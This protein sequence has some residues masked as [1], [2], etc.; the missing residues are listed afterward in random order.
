MEGQASSVL[1]ASGGDRVR[2]EC[3]DSSG[4]REGL[5]NEIRKFDLQSVPKA[6]R[7]T[8][9]SSN[10]QFPDIGICRENQ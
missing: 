6:A 1:C 5:D 10:D 8:W 9:L 7:Q 2:C 4:G 3:D